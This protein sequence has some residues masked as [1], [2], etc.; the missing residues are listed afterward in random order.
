MTIYWTKKSIP[1]LK[2]LSPEVRKSNYR[3]A[4]CL[5]RKHVEYRVCSVAFTLMVII[6]PALFKM[7][8]PF[9][10]T[11]VRDVLW[12]LVIIFPSL[13]VLNQYLYFTMRKYYGH[14]LMK[15]DME[16]RSLG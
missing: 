13:L 8:F 3:E 9:L 12:A 2:N 4:E 7:A 14:I 16:R 1:E 15:G 11:Y 10:N 5:A 6:S